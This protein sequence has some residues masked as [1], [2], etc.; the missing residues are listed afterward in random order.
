MKA[1]GCVGAGSSPSGGGPPACGCIAARC[2]L[3]RCA[4]RVHALLGA[5]PATAVRRAALGDQ[6]PCLASALPAPVPAG[7]R[8]CT[9]VAWGRGWPGRWSGETTS[10]E[11]LAVSS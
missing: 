1:T 9:G 10:N 8:T 3:R 2:C 11:L 6:R 4:P 7:A 5:Q